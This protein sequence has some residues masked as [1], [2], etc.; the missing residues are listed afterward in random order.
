M[1]ILITGGAG[2]IGSA[3]VRAAVGKGDTVINVDA[4]KY[5]G[6]LENLKSVENHPNYIFEKAD[7]CDL[8]KIKEILKKYE[9]DAIMH[10][11]A[12]S[13]VDRSI[14][15]P[16]LFIKTN[17]NGTF[18]L[19]EAAKEYWISKGRPTHFRFHHVSTDEVYGS[20]GPTGKFTESTAYDPRSPYS[21]S[22]AASDHLVRAWFSTFGLPVL[23]TNCSN[24]YGK[25]QFPEKLIPKTIISALCREPITV[26]GNGKN[27]RDW[28]FVEDH[29]RALYMVL[30][31]G[32]IGLTYNIGG[33]EEQTNIDIVTKICLILDEKLK[34]TQSSKDLISFVPDRPGHD[35]RYAVDSTR[36]Y[37]ELGWK[38]S[39]SLDTGLEKTVQWYVENEKWWKYLKQKNNTDR[40]LGVSK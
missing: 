11:A 18:N 34:I 27:I 25:N 12:E 21:A 5:S 8:S 32:K 28:L 24:N 31:F 3:V 17:I 20:L 6:S 1:K 39:V 33:D 37:K 38:P 4:L 10:L 40:R 29:V 2:F 16:E 13:H 26:Y 23:I 35:L 14:E 19:L 30:E 36:I 22:K 9:P 15:G 7:I